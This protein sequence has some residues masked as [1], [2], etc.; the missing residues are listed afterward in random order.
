MITKDNNGDLSI[1][2]GDDGYL[3]ISGLDTTKN[4]DICFWI[5]DPISGTVIKEYHQTS[6]YQEEVTVV[7][8]SADTSKWHCGVKPRTLYYGVTIHDE[9]LGTH[10]TFP[11]VGTTRKLTIFSSGHQRLF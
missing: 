5:M 8:Q 4:L 7:L 9:L 2:A 3:K 11:A 6:I 1:M 10:T